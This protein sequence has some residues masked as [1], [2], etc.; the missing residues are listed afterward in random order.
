MALH[1]LFLLGLML[2]AEL[3][4][5]RMESLPGR[6]ISLERIVAS[7]PSQPVR[8]ILYWL[9]ISSSHFIPRFIPSIADASPM[10]LQITEYDHSGRGDTTGLGWVRPGDP[11]SE[12]VLALIK[13]R[14]GLPLLLNGLP[15][16]DT[17]SE[18]EIAK[19]LSAR[20]S[21]DRIAS[22]S[23]LARLRSGTYGTCPTYI[24]H[25]TADQVAP[26]S[27]AER[28]VAELQAQ[29]IRCGMLRIVGGPHIHDTSLKP[30]MKKWEEQVAPGYSFLFDVLQKT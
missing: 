25:G 7:L 27:A 1:I 4:A 28:F 9:L 13:E 24:I 18:A 20:P 14:I 26:F 30:G 29:E 8:A 11:R 5:V 22:V 6:N 17:S 23:P 16:R 12:L 19:W 2:W 10:I 3:D 21:A 15:P